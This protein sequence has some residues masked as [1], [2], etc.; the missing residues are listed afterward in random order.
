M[1]MITVI[2]SRLRFGEATGIDAERGSITSMKVND[3]HLYKVDAINDNRINNC[4][5]KRVNIGKCSS[6]EISNS[7]LDHVNAGKGVL[8]FDSSAFLSN[9]S[10]AVSHNVTKLTDALSPK[11]FRAGAQLATATL[12]APEALITASGLNKP[13]NKRTFT[14]VDAKRLSAKEIKG[15]TVGN[16][17]KKPL[18]TGN[19][20]RP[21]LEALFGRKEGAKR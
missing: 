9:L 4:F 5:L 6:T 15:L 17:N 20:N 14:S 12:A 21:T 1:S 11:A 8:I 3:S 18:E 19:Q 13:D 16:D 10:K 2:D 7:Y